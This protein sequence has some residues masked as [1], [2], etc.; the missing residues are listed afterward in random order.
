MEVQVELYLKREGL[1]KLLVS[2]PPPPSFVCSFNEE[3]HNCYSY[4]LMFINCVLAT[5]S[6]RALSKDEFTQTFVLPRVKRASKYSMLC[7][8]ISQNHFYIVDS[9]KRSSREGHSD[10]EEDRR[11]RS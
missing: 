11:S 7:R 2:P 1:E 3:N 8:E 9:P 10:E 6:K 4:T 5:Q